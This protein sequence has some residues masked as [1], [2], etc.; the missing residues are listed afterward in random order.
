MK[1]LFCL[2]AIIFLP[3]YLYPQVIEEWVARYDGPG[4][5]YDEANSIA[6]DQSGN[7]Y[8]TGRSEQSSLNYDCATVKYD[9]FGTEK[10]V[11][12][13]NG[14]EN[15]WD[16]GKSIAVD[17][18]GYPYVLAQS[19]NRYTTFKYSSLLGT[20]MWLTTFSDCNNATALA[21]DNLENVYVTGGGYA[22][23]T[24]GNDFTT[25][26][27]SHLGNELWVQRYS[28][29]DSLDDNAYAIAVD[30]FGNAYVTGTSNEYLN[31]YDYATVKY[32][33]DGVLQWA[34]RYNGPADLDDIAHSIAVDNQG[35][36]YVTGQS[37]NFYDNNDYAT[38]KYNPDGV[39]QWVK[40]YSMGGDNAAYAIAVDLSGNVYVTGESEGIGTSLDY[41][42][43]KYNT[44]GDQ[45]WVS[46]YNGPDSTVDAALS[47]ALDGSGNVYVTGGSTDSGNEDC[48]TVK[49]NSNGSEIWVQR[50]N[51]PGNGW[52]QGKAI[53]VDDAGNVYV[54]GGGYGDGTKTDYVTIKY[55]QPA[56]VEQISNNIP[57]EFILSQ[58][59]PNPFNPKT[60][61]RFYSPDQQLITL[62]V[63]DVLGNA[64]AIL[65]N[66]ELPGGE[67]EVDFNA[68]T[69]SG[70]VSAK[71]K[72]ASG[73]YF[74]QLRAGEY[75]AV[76]KMILIK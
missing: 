21:L 41:A 69:L 29:P 40:R 33:T 56:G 65:V 13:Y 60:R 36:V 30:D 55:S 68:T 54:T 8:V 43:I 27:Y 4:N 62:T 75:T 42:T 45:I 28:G 49:Y 31:N 14:P 44:T 46:R 12:R 25:I 5:N 23:G 64:V 74:Y 2:T 20:E 73:V 17:A 15:E 51:G 3:F 38:I 19:F 11:Q 52:D 47:L 6:I 57:D 1:R 32:S 72:H 50:Y 10:W 35:N 67:Y 58:N 59:F 53:A 22:G 76:K 34:Q 7:V 48:T 9:P 18:G 39:Q 26:K 37:E 63:Y 70:S 71:G 66:E 24:S 61:I 16:Y